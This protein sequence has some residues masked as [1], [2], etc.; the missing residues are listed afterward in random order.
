MKKIYLVFVLATLL[1]ISQASAITTIVTATIDEL[2]LESPTSA[3]TITKYAGTW[4]GASSSVFT[5]AA[6]AGKCD[7][8]ISTTNNGDAV[9]GW[10]WKVNGN[11]AYNPKWLKRGDG[12]LFTIS[13]PATLSLDA[14]GIHVV[15]AKS[16]LDSISYNPT[17]CG[18][19]LTFYP[20]AIAMT[21]DAKTYH[22]EWSISP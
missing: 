6:Y 10:N 20:D 17:S 14:S 11:L 12:L 15:C 3:N 21:P 9:N 4:C 22:F 8:L 13:S 19:P 2:V 5:S 18:G 16:G 7:Y 1:M